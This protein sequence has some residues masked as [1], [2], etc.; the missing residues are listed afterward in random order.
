MI[1][2]K[3]IVENKT[4]IQ[5]FNHKFIQINS[6]K[7]FWIVDKKNKITNEHVFKIEINHPWSGT[8]PSF[9]NSLI[10][11][12]SEKYSGK[13]LIIILDDKNMMDATDCTKKYFIVFSKAHTPWL[14]IIGKNANIFNSSATHIKKEDVVLKHKIILKNKII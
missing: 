12:I 13:K 11:P 5:D 8:A 14:D 6:G 1:I 7:I 2:I 9:I 3:V 10:Q 4:K